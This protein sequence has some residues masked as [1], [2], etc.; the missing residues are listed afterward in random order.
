MKLH[1]VWVDLRAG[2]DAET[3]LPSPLA[4]ALTTDAPE[5]RARAQ[6]LLSFMVTMIKVKNG[7][8]A[9]HNEVPL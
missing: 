1:G 4:C 8:K 9:E 5:I 2:S 7:E 3:T 6:E